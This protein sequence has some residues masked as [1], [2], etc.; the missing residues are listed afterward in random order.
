MAN[1][2]RALEP[3]YLKIIGE[4]AVDGRLDHVRSAWS[5]RFPVVGR[6]QLRAA[7]NGSRYL[8]LLVILPFWTNLL[9]RTYALIAVL[10]TRGYINFH[11]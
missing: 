4:V 9:I 8:L 5:W 2:V 3:L 6:H 7:E 1:Y 11:A 10:R